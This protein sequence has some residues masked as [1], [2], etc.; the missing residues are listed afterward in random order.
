MRASRP[1]PM[2]DA[3][4]SVSMD[5]CNRFAIPRL[6]FRRSARRQ[7]ARF[8]RRLQPNF[9]ANMAT[10]QIPISREHV[11]S[12]NLI[13]VDFYGC[14]NVQSEWLTDEAHLFTGGTEDDAWRD[15]KSGCLLISFARWQKHFAMTSLQW[16]YSKA[17]MPRAAG[18]IVK[19]D[20]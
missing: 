20:C 8:H 16:T 3:P 15:K 1:Q 5:A 2:P 6:T 11:N 19:P 12:L 10:R 4:V 7:F 13:E 18:F 14:E 9:T 17:A